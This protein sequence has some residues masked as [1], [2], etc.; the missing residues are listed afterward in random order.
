MLPI[1]DFAELA[2]SR[3][4]ISGFRR[5]RVCLLGGTGFIGT[6]LV[7]SLSYLSFAQN[8]EIDLTI[9]TRHKVNASVK[10]QNTSFKKL[11]IEEFDFSQ[12]T[13]DLG[14]FDFFIIGATPTSIKPGINSRNFF[15]SPTI[16][17]T[18]SVIDSAKRF[19]NFPRVLNLSSGAVYGNQPM[20]IELRPEGPAKTLEISD[21]DYRAS[22]IV[23]EDM[24]TSANDKNIL[25][26]ISPRLFTFYGPGLPIE[27][28][29]A[30]GN[31]IRDGLNGNRINV[32]GSPDTRRS[33][34]F[35]TDLVTWLLR[36]ILE[37]K[38]ETYN[39][40]SEV[41]LSM[42][43]LATKVSDLTCRRGVLLLNPQTT[44][45][46]YVPS[47]ASF[48]SIYDVKENIELEVGLEQWIKW[49]KQQ[50]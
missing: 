46:N 45:N 4:D 7:Q 12:G 9:Y 8:I 38:N 41:N 19:R 30:I 37:P 27:Q 2:L 39:I 14:M 23:S 29:F 15:Y 40:G 1:S 21:D 49:L 10:F 50:I 28:H 33:Y 32:Q 35:P 25:K 43:E 5:T 26:A 3:V 17:A 47:T 44:P 16:N 18:S 36:A 6:W 11:S 22:K 20:N 42:L 13:C 34:M 31:F 24:L 48:R